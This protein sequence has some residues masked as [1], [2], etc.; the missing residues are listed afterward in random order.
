VNVSGASTINIRFADLSDTHPGPAPAHT[1]YLGA[2]AA[3]WGRFTDPTPVGSSEFTTPGNERAWRRT[4]L[5]PVLMQE[6][7]RHPAVGVVAAGRV[8]DTLDV[9]GPL[10]LGG[11][12][13]R[14]PQPLLCPD[15]LDPIE[16]LPRRKSR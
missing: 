2:N 3:H 15:L 16:P 1:G 12:Y 14:D 8:A 5:S 9:G 4:E 13:V 10:V 7:G 6:V 11:V